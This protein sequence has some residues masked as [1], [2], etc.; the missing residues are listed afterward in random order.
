MLCSYLLGIPASRWPSPLSIP[1]VNTW[2]KP[3]TTGAQGS[4]PPQPCADEG[5][6]AVVRGGDQKNRGPRV[7]SSTSNG[8]TCK[9][10]WQRAALA[11][12]FG[13]RATS[14]RSRGSPLGYDCHWFRG[15]LKEPAWDT[16][17]LQSAR[18]RGVFRAVYARLLLDEHP[19][20]YPRSPHP[21]VGALDARSGVSNAEGLSCA[22]RRRSS[23]PHVRSPFCFLDG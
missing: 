23:M 11:V 2:S 21:V 19:L 16:L 4:R 12:F 13:P 3:A 17:L 22:R 15:E 9:T 18:E 8:L 1:G 10:I 14:S 6:V 5:D 7:C 20:C